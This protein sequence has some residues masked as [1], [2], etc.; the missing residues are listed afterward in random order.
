M[1]FSNFDG[2]KDAKVF[3]FRDKINPWW[4]T[5]SWVPLLSW[6]IHKQ[7]CYKQLYFWLNLLSYIWLFEPMDPYDSNL[8]QYYTVWYRQNMQSDG[9]THPTTKH[10]MSFFQ[11]VNIFLGSK[12]FEKTFKIILEIK[13]SYIKESNCY[14]DSSFDKIIP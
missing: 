10:F 9:A 5:Y 4:T 14:L 7:K 2:V 6:N 3:F 12:F 13:K 11:G 1:D 8:K